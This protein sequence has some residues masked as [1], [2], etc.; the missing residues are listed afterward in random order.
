MTSAVSTIAITGHRPAKLPRWAPPYICRVL[1]DLVKRYPGATWLTGGAIGVDQ[2]T[3]KRR[4]GLGQIVELIL[5]FPP[6]IQ[7]ARWS[8]SQAIGSSL[9]SIESPLTMGEVGGSTLA[10]GQ[11]N[12]SW[13]YSTLGPG[14]LPVS[15]QR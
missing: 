7:A 9:C 14:K 11:A 10:V 3:T 12:Y 15:N 13:K 6:E 2:I 4:L 5:P 1:Q 8:L